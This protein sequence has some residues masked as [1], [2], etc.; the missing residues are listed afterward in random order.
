MAGVVAHIDA[1]GLRRLD[2]VLDSG[3]L[4]GVRLGSNA[5]VHFFRKPTFETD[6]LIAP[7][8]IGE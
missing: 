5:P 1:T 8:A 7:S 6:F 3:R 4:M 2:C